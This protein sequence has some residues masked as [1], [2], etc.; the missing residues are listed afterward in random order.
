M[1]NKEILKKLNS[2]FGS[3]RA[4]WLKGKIFDFFAEPS[5]FN[6]LQ[7][8]R[9][10]VL[11]GGRGTGKTT[12]L[13]GLSYQGQF[14]LLNNDIAAFDNKDFIGIYHRVD[15]NHVRAFINEELS[16]D[17][18]KKLFSHYLN[19]VLCREILKFVKWHK[20]LNPSDEVLDEHACNIFSKSINIKSQ[21]KNQDDLL[22]YLDLEMVEFQSQINNIGDGVLPNLSM[23]DV[24]IKIITEKIIELSQF[25]N[26]IFYII[27]DEYE[28]FEDYQQQIVN[29]LIKHNTE[30]YTFKIGVREMGW[31][32][33]HTLNLDE[34]LHDPADYVLIPIEQKLTKSQFS[35]FAK[36]VCEQRIRQLIPDKTENDQYLIETAL[37]SLTIEEE[38]IQLKVEKSEYYKTIHKLSD[39]YKRKIST[40]TPLYKYFLS[41]WAFWQK[42]SIESII[43]D[44][45]LNTKNWDT[46]YGNYK[47]E[48]L[49]K[50]RKGRGMGGI[51]KYYCGWNT[52]LQLSRGNIRYM[53][54]LVYRAYE[55][56][57][58]S[59]EELATPVDVKLQTYAAQEIGQKNLKQLEDFWKNGAKL[60]KILLGFGRIFQI[61]SSEGGKFAPERNQFT[62]ENSENINEEC[63]EIINAAIMH[64]ALVRSPGNKLTDTAHT[65]DYLY[66]I[67]PIFSAFFV[68]SYRKKRKIIVEQNDIL[69]IISS[70]KE[71]INNVLR[72]C[73]VNIASDINLPKQMEM[74][75]NFYND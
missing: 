55:K 47:Y 22:S 12:V 15:T 14:A 10:C 52:Y 69:G 11:E 1:N 28:N 34:L 30:F 65:R 7:D 18:W 13:R 49:F 66:A 32:V 73:N 23:A 33:K 27:L 29:T 45:L 62:I 75:E 72:K 42:K 36:N 25:N 44:Y 17:N 61:L 54:E 5:Y 56:H 6:A 19:L 16:D 70:P 20:S 43:D 38:A 63:R 53:M 26:K 9:P 60:T 67:H 31:R 21:C 48:M 4:E 2:L 68:F 50:I 3:Y 58:E 59:G 64:L 37:S 74:F 71:T 24:P 40:L 8:N 39:D 46:R 57:L 51:Q 35:E 41:Y